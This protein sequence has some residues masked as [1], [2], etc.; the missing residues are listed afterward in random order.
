LLRHFCRRIGQHDCAKPYPPAIVWV[1]GDI[2]LSAAFGELDAKGAKAGAYFHPASQYWIVRAQGISGQHI[3]E[4]LQKLFYVNMAVELSHLNH[5]TYRMVDAFDDD[6]RPLAAGLEERIASYWQSFLE[7]IFGL[8]VANPVS[9]FE[10]ARKE[11]LQEKLTTLTNNGTQHDDI[12]INKDELLSLIGQ[13]EASSM[14]FS[15]VE[16]TMSSRKRLI[17]DL[18]LKCGVG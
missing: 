5:S 9:E 14:P 13:Y 8:C 12:A 18:R 7:G 2:L 15:P 6:G 3:A 10:I 1:V 4:T 17:A 11:I 16:Y